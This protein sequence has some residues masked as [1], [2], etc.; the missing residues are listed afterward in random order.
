M[1]YRNENNPTRHNKYCVRCWTRRPQVGG[2]WCEECF[3]DMYA[4]AKSNDDPHTCQG[5]CC[6]QLTEPGKPLCPSCDSFYRGVGH[7]TR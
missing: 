2:Q 3:N 1:C 5:P 6:S 4:I 7:G